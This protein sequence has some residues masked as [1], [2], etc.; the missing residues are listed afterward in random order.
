MAGSSHFNKEYTWPYKRL[1]L[2]FDPVAVDWVG[3]QLLQAKR[4]EYFKEDRPLNPPAKHIYLAD[5]KYHL[6]T[7]DFSRID[8]VKAGSEESIFI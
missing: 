6:G 8:L 1:V 5:T 3:V 7:A 4:K 2:G